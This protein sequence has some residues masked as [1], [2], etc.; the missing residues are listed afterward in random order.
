MHT[1]QVGATVVIRVCD[2]F[3]RGAILRGGPSDG[4]PRA[5]VTPLAQATK[6]YH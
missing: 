1:A 3:L 4:A 6:Y 5:K 2:D